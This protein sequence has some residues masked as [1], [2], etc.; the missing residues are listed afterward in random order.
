MNAL[1]WLLRSQDL[2]EDEHKQCM[3]TAF[4]SSEAPVLGLKNNYAE[5]VTK[6]QAILTAIDEIG[7]SLNDRDDNM[8]ER[9]DQKSIT[10]VDTEFV[11]SMVWPAQVL[12]VLAYNNEQASLGLKKAELV[13]VIGRALEILE[14]ESLTRVRASA[15]VVHRLFST[16]V[17]V[18]SKQEARA[19]YAQDLEQ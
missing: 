17:A 10:L 15:Q 4:R 5:T 7:R 12:E 11:S 1:A 9:S 18:M 16:L 8:A 14:V 3:L 2:I 13:K 19:Q 6:S